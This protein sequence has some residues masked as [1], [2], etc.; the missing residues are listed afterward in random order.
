MSC[1][2]TREPSDAKLTYQW[3]CN[4]MKISGA[5]S[6]TYTYTVP[7]DNEDANETYEFYCIATA[8]RN[9]K[10]NT[11]KSNVLTLKV[12][13]EYSISVDADVSN[14]TY[15]VGQSPKMSATVR[16][17]GSTISASVSWKLLDKNGKELGSNSNIATI[18]SN[19][20]ITTKAT[21]EADG[22]KITVQAQYTKDGYTYTGSKTITLKPASAGTVT[23]AAGTGSNIKASTIQ[24]KVKGALGSNSAAAVYV[25]FGSPSG[26]TLTKSSGSSTAVGTANC[27][28]STTSGQKLSDVYVKLNNNAT[29][30]SVEYTAYDSNDNALVTGKISFTSESGNGGVTAVGI[31][32][33]DADVL[34]LIGEEFANVSEE[35]DYIKFDTIDTK[36][37]R[38]LDGYKGIVK[39]DSAKDVTDSTKYFLSGS[40]DNV[41]DL[42]LLPRTDFYGTI[43]IDY[44]AY[45]SRNKS[46][47]E[48][49]LT[50][51]VVK[52]TSSSNFTD[53]TNANVGS[54]AADAID[55]MA[56]NELVGGVG[57]KKFNP[58]GTMTRGDFVLI[59]YRMAGEPS[60]AGVNNPF[61]DVKTGDYFY[62]A[63][64]WA[65]KNSVVGGMGAGKFAPK[66]NISREQIASIL[67]RYSGATKATGSLN[68]F[69]DASKVSGYAVDPMKWAVGAGIIGGSNNK[70]DPQGN[71]TR[72]Q[73]VVMLHRFLNK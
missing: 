11:L 29:S 50:F 46:L 57:N 17:K 72:A 32:L 10:D 58:T 41:E 54:W 34:E 16:Y 49:T 2:A 43:K 15:T 62:N 47:G 12:S 71:A 42:Y 44:T 38:L 36:K 45:S 48:G 65:Y 26:C 67:Y 37:A 69:T 25:K 39:I 73:V 5:T 60:V 8:T 53:V 30:G 18:S 35:V 3:Y 9:G 56:E 22:Q 51:E 1:T 13:R 68:A 63:V 19:G 40:S 64:M 6:A 24:T 52:K 4:G 33:K 31:S 59:L 55:F 61:N 28:F 70:L 20:T 27:Y 21:G 7:A 14:A 66:N 23:M